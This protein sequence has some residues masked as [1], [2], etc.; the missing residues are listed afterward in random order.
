LR[1]EETEPAV[2]VRP[3]DKAGEGG[4]QYA[5]TVEDD[6]RTIVGEMGTAWSAR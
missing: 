2:A 4:A 1:G 6:E 3:Q 5:L